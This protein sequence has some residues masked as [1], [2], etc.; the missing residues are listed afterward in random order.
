VHYVYQIQ[1]VDY[2]EEFYTGSTDN[3][4][5]RLDSHDAGRSPHTA[6]HK[7]WRLVTYHAFANR[8][9]ALDF[10]AYLKNRLRPCFHQMSSPVKA[11]PPLA[12]PI[13]FKPLH[14]RSAVHGDLIT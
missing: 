6:K 10:E 5:A 12:L 4:K 9:K 8:E 13:A 2:P 7:P 1:S 3:L 11:S 14:R